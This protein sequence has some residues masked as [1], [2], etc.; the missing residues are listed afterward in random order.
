MRKEYEIRLL[1]TLDKIAVIEDVLR[2][3]A[4]ILRIITPDERNTMVEYEVRS[5]PTKIRR[6]FVNGKRNKG[7][8]GA[9]LIVKAL[10]EHGGSLS[11]SDLCAI[12]EHHGFS[13]SSVNSAARKI[14]NKVDYANGTFE[15]KESVL[16]RMRAG[17]FA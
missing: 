8:S 13:R 10:K 7:I 1:C 14:R 17:T 9:D 6:R 4:T 16:D 15:L 11:R 12:F 2:G 3:E 5:P